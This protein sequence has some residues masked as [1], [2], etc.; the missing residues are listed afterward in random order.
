LPPKPAK[1]GRNGGAQLKPG[2]SIIGYHHPFCPILKAPTKTKS[3][4]GFAQ[5]KAAF[6]R[7]ALERK[8]KEGWNLQNPIPLSFP[9]NGRKEPSPNS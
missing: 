9:K 4:Q 6:V 7:E 5:K 3:T 2:Y 8:R 1:K